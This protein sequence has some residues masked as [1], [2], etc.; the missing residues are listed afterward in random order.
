MG[1][2]L[3]ITLLMVT[4]CFSQVVISVDENVSRN[5]DKSLMLALGASALLPGLGEYYLEE[6]NMVRPFVWIDAALWVT[7]VGS[8]FVGEHYISSAHNY[9]VRHAGLGTS[10]KDIDFLNT[11]GDYRSRRGVEGQNSSPDM[12]EDYNQAMLRS[13]KKVDE[14]YPDNEEYQWDWGSS[15]N[16]ESTRHMDEFKNRLRHFRVSRIVFQASIG[17]LVLNRIVSMLDAMR[18]YRSTSSKSL[19]ENVLFVPEL[20]ENGGGLNFLCNF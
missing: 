1:K 11:V 18:I 19:S 13:G 2:L 16:P 12:D 10:D 7:V 6:Q 9:A 4:A 8:Y 14:D 20:Q 5:N 17:A 3:A 15:D